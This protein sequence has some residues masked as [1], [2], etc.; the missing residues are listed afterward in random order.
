MYQHAVMISYSRRDIDWTRRLRDHL[1]HDGLTVWMDEEGLHPGTEAWDAAIGAAIKDAGCVVAVMSPDASQSEWVG[2]ELA[3]AETYEIPIIPILMRGHPR[4]AVPFRL[5]NHQWIDARDDYGK[6]FYQ[7]IDSIAR[8][9]NVE[10]NSM[11]QR[12]AEQ[13]QVEQA[14]QAELARRQQ[15]DEAKR[16][17]RITERAQRQAV[18]RHRS[19]KMNKAIMWGLGG[20][21]VLAVVIGLLTS[22]FSDPGNSGAIDNNSFGNNS[23][24]SNSGGG[25]DVYVPAYCDGFTVGA[26]D[27]YANENVI[28]VI[29][30]NAALTDYL[31]DYLDAV[32]TTI[33]VDGRRI[34]SRPQ[35]SQ[36]YSS[37]LGGYAVDIMY[38]YG[39]LS[40]GQHEV[41]F[42]QTWD[43]M[44]TT[45]GFYSFYGPGSLNTSSGGRCVFQVY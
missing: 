14:T 13:Q 6:A 41:S 40:P 32:N 22:A 1:R 28:F 5:V 30:W 42:E 37:V 34:T 35:V 11:R 4:D 10:T 43:Y 7:L 2:R 29:S 33:Y 26:P 39:S 44:I 12:R 23:S 27:V 25:G 45:D 9:L 38:E 8:Q 19:K 31:Q 3:F 36:F 20:I 15:E 18:Q 21:T 24:N 16:Q 17:Q